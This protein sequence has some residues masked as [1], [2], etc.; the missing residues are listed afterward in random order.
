MGTF[1]LLERLAHEALVGNKSHSLFLGDI[2]SNVGSSFLNYFNSLITSSRLSWSLPFRGRASPQV[3]PLGPRHLLSPLFRDR[4][5]S[6]SSL[7][8]QGISSSPPL[9]VQGISPSPP[10]RGRA[11]PESSPPSG[12]GY[13]LSPPLQRWGI[14]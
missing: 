2:D 7:Q 1:H 13:L 8:G 12:P 3:L 6:E 4:T 5:S 14:S 11:S 9:R 10:F